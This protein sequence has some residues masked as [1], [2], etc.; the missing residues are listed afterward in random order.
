M[1]APV[2]PHPNIWWKALNFLLSN[3]AQAELAVFPGKGE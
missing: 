3:D 1:S 2:N